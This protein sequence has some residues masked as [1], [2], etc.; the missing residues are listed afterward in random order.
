VAVE[1]PEADD[2]L[3]REQRLDLEERLGVDEPSITRACRSRRLLVGHDVG[4]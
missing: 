2:Q 3:G 4:R 1:A